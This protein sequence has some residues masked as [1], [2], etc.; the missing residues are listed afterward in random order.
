MNPFGSKYIMSVYK[1]IADQVHKYIDIY[2]KVI[3]DIIDTWEF[4]RLRRIIQLG[5]V[6]VSYPSATH[7]RFMHS[8]GAHH[9]ANRMGQFLNK[10][11]PN[12][13]TEDEIKQVSL[14]ALIHDIGHG[15]FS[16]M[17][18]DTTRMLCKN[19]EDSDC[20]NKYGVFVRHENISE[21]I[22]LADESEIDIILEKEG[23]DRKRIGNLIQGRSVDDKP[24][25]NQIINSQ[26]DAD[27][28]DYL[29]RDSVAT[30]VSFGMYN[31][32]RLFDMME[33]TKDGTITI[34]EKGVQSIEQVVLALYMQ[35][36]RVYFHK[37]VR[38]YEYM[39][40]LFISQLI[41]KIDE[42][43]N[44]ASLPFLKDFTDKPNWK[45]LM[46]LTDDVIYTQ[47]HYSVA[48]EQNDDFIKKLA[49][50]I[51]RRNL[52]KSIPL[53]EDMAA[54]V[55]ENSDKVNFIVRKHGYPTVSWD[56][57]QFGSR[58]YTPYEE[59]DRNAIMIKMKEGQ[60]KQL[61][62]VS[63]VIASLTKPKYNNLLIFPAP[64]RNEITKLVTEI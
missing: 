32:E 58:Y 62:E 35:F 6:S 44:I 22:V 55:L 4:Q 60:L 24:F 17:F 2:D 46:T 51:L 28:L 26:L 54:K 47:L 29:M 9:V 49:N 18:E 37:T 31:L 14:T 21:Q 3:I 57:D 38:C 10:K 11:H 16:H 40:K 50:E 20:N 33:L 45:T 34:R 36:S 27:A 8:L 48:K 53:T 52:F 30:G 64:C 15:P 59:T 12:I 1:S 56:I 43:K 5:G 13:F 25:K 23:Y 19:F 7:S 61:S 41:Q 63:D 42:G 39:L